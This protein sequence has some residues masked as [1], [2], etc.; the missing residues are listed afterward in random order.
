M[1]ENSPHRLHILLVDDD[2][3]E[4]L[5]TQDLL[6]D[7]SYL[8]SQS[9]PVGFELDWVATYEE[10]L[11]A[12]ARDQHDVYLV[13]YYLGNRDGLELLREV[14]ERGCT[15]PIILMTG[16]GNYDLDI[17]AMK[18][19][20]TDY[21]AKGEVNAPLLERT[22]RYAIERKRAEEEI[23]RNAARAQVLAAL[24][25]AFVEASLSY[26]D[27]LAAIL[28]HIA[29]A[30]GDGCILRLVSE[31]GEWLNP[32]AVGLPGEIA[33]TFDQD[34]A[35]RRQRI[36]E[37]LAGAVFQSAQPL[38]LAEKPAGEPH[39]PK[40]L[41][42]ESVGLGIRATQNDLDSH[43][44]REMQDEMEVAY[45]G[46]GLNAHSILIVPLRTQ[47]QSIGTLSALRFQEDRP[48]TEDDLVFFQDV[49]GR[50]ALAIENA[51]LHAEVQKSAITDALT[52]VYNRRG[53]LELGRREIERA[54]RFNRPLSAI[55]V[56]LDNFKE[57][58]DTY[59]HVTGDTIL[60]KVAERLHGSV[61]EVDTLSRYGGDEFILLLPETDSFMA[62][63]VAERIRQRV[64]IPIVLP[65]SPA[66]EAAFHLTASLGVASLMTETKDL[67]VLIERADAASYH[68]KRNGRNRVQ[69]G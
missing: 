22:I 37:G 40:S 58:N 25:Q 16:R 27:V 65:L 50:A 35:T 32:V 69:I 45:W 1:K 49:A 60:R 17:E 10:A 9:Q 46:D 26:P 48:Y 64:A 2:E 12:V 8:S 18:A 55:M 6:T 67:E 4:Y 31:D 3:E 68:A 42:Q 14:T 11:E 59:G 21:L 66:G 33:H 20:A 54:R 30:F 38:L 7:R 61:R 57:V 15:K 39:S 24:S 23:R 44:K 5:L 19:G 51:L 52:E 43:Q 41:L 29:E 53:L 34:L 28:Q 62:C 36:G 47:G 63:A 13:D 56:D